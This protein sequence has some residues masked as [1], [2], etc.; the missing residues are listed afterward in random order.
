MQIS[1]FFYF[2]GI[3]F[4]NSKGLVFL[5]GYYFLRFSGSHVTQ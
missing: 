4:C 1:D 5:A 3:H 2:A